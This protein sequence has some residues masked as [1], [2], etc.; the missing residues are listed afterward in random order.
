MG[1]LINVAGS[2]SKLISLT[3]LPTQI[4]LTILEFLNL[5]PLV[6]W[7]YKT[8]PV[9]SY[10]SIEKAKKKLGYFATKSNEDILIESYDWY[11]E[12]RK[13]FLGKE[14]TTHRTVWNFKIVEIA[15]KFF[16]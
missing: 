13:E 3:V 9:D 16:R 15:Q 5:S 11:K 14:G 10:V 6:A 8:F 2:K 1:S 7:H 12:H 4:A